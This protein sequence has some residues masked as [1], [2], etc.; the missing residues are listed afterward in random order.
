[1]DKDALTAPFSIA[2]GKLRQALKASIKPY[3]GPS[4]GGL[5]NHMWAAVVDRNGIVQAV[6]HSGAALGDEW[7]A[8]RAIAIEKPNT[9]NALIL[10]TFAFSIANLYSGAQPGDFLYGILETNPVDTASMYGGD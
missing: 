3:G 5:D 2:H 10:P 8:S 9:A 7:P 4:N 1:M 6:C